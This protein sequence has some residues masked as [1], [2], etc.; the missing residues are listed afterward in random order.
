MSERTYELHVEANGLKSK[1]AQDANTFLTHG[2]MTV[3][4]L[5]KIAH[6]ANDSHVYNE[7]RR[8]LAV[9]QMSRK[10]GA[11]NIPAACCLDRQMRYLHK[12]L[13]VDLS[14]PLLVRIE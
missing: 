8:N 1:Y 9:V 10:I 14:Q 11:N 4:L 2:Q 7:E 5:F 3:N 12:V 6:Q 13:P